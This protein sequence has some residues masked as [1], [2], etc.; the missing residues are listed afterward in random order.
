M[1]EIRDDMQTRGLKRNSDDSRVF[2]ET[3]YYEKCYLLTRAPECKTCYFQAWV[4]HEDGKPKMKR[5]SM[6]N[7]YVNI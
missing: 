2:C 1:I 7:H 4:W 6:P 5:T 3:C